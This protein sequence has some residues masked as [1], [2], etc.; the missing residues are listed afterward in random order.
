MVRGKPVVLS[1]GREWA[2]KTLAYDF[3]KELRDRYP[4]ETPITDPNDHDDLLALLERYDA[5]V[6]TG[7]SKVGCGVAHFFTREN[8]AHGGRTIGFWLTRTDDTVTDFSFKTAVS[9]LPKGNDAEL[10]EACRECVYELVQDLKTDHF[11]KAAGGG[12]QVVC[13]VSGDPV[14]A[15]E[16]RLDYAPTTLRDLVWAFRIIEGWEEAIPPGIL[17]A[18]ADAQLTTQFADIDAMARFRSYHAENARF[19]VVSKD[20]TRGRLLASRSTPV[21]NPIGF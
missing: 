16:A 3:F 6:T 21:R 20:V 5:V 10:V 9:G 14:D 17:T 19:R 13:E 15:Y 1:N 4:L 18:P 12:W 11:K 8:E 7:P 2:N